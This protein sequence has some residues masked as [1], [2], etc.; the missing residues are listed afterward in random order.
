MSTQIFDYRLLIVGIFWKKIVLSDKLLY[1]KGGN[2]DNRSNLN[3]PYSNKRLFFQNYA[4]VS[5]LSSVTIGQSEV[6]YEKHG[7]C[8]NPPHPQRR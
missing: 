2:L 4:T 6:T 3:P 7:C 5:L 8:I 1:T